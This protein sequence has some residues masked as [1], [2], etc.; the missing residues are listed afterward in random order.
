[1]HLPWSQGIT[2]DD[3]II[4]SLNGFIGEDVVVTVK[5]DGENTSISKD[6]THARSLDSRHHWSRNLIKKLHS[7][8]GWMLPPN[9][10]ICGENIFA[11]HSIKYE[12]LDDYFQV[13]N[14]WDRE[15]DEC[16][17]WDET[18]ST[19]ELLGLTHVPVL[20]KGI[21]DEHIIKNLPL[22]LEKNEG[23][24]VRVS[25][26]FNRQDFG[27]KVAKFVRSGH[28]QENSQHWMN[29]PETEINLIKH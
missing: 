22:D 26:S 15:K 8:I 1:M 9:L 17:S 2:C 5:L 24:V 3:K 21:W 27:K 29:K 23:Y 13:F 6:Y 10:I 18:V 11:T 28:V 14:V 25:P 12:D 7:Q 4:K 20:Y 19:C 16:L